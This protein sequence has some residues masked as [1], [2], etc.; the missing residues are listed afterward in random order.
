MKIEKKSWPEM[1]DR[2]AKGE[3]TFDVRLADF[4]CKAGDVLVF[5]EWNPDSKRYTGRSTE[6]RIKYVMKTKEAK[7]WTESDVKRYGFLV[8][9]LE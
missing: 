9:G 5:R 7:F 4:D 8:M 6:K 1:F 3:K 2:I